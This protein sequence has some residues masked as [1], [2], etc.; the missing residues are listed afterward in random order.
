[1]KQIDTA[2]RR[3][4]RLKFDAG[5][6]ENPYVDANLASS[7]TATPEAIALA[8][9]AAQRSVVLLKNEKNLLPLQ[10]QKVGR[11][12]VL[13]TYELAV[14]RTDANF[15]KF[16]ISTIVVTYLVGLALLL[17][18]LYT[19]TAPESEAGEPRQVREGRT[20]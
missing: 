19:K 9:R 11:L 18:S 1:M 13:G 8:R 4:L 7:L 3:V 12:L 14:I 10:P 15:L 6:F 20:A 5:L 17:A 16:T 2:V